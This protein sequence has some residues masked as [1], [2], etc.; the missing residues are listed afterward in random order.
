MGLTQYEFAKQVLHCAWGS[1]AR[2]ETT[3]PPSGAVL[4]R[5]HNLAMKQ[6]DVHRDNHKRLKREQESERREE[7]RRFKGFSDLAIRFLALYYQELVGAAPMQLLVHRFPDEPEAR[8]YLVTELYG[9]DAI[10]AA[11]ALMHF[12]QGLGSANAKMRAVAVK[13]VEQMGIWHD[14]LSSIDD[15][16]A[17]R[18]VKGDMSID[19]RDWPSTPSR[20]EVTPQGG[21]PSKTHPRQ[22]RTGGKK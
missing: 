4:L 22:R 9:L 12:L 3:H 17:V 21:S 5:L 8:G 19:D 15:A 14:K 10:S 11:E 6:A 7:F 16:A 2:Y 13:A 18:L 20:R 1:V